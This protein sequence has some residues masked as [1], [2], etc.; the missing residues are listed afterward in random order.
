[1]PL[2]KSIS[3]RWFF[4]QIADAR[5]CLLFS[6]AICM[7]YMRL[8]STLFLLLLRFENQSSIL[9]LIRQK[10][11]KEVI[12]RSFLK[13]LIILSLVIPVDS[14][15][16]RY[17]KNVDGIATIATA[18]DQW[19]WSWRFSYGILKKNQ[20]NSIIPQNFWLLET[21]RKN[22]TEKPKRNTLRLPFDLNSKERIWN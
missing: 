9:S 7:F 5:F 17:L 20:R 3:L 2:G 18:E 14:A 4:Q 21:Y 15:F 1:M 12:V 10:K 22:P 19:Q 13:K 6:S 16:S 11:W 8:Y